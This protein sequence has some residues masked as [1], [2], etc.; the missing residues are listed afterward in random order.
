VFRY[1]PRIAGPYLPA[2]A[3]LIH[4]TS[5]PDEAARA[6][7]GDAIVADVRAFTEAVLPQVKESTR[8][9]PAPRPEPT[10]TQ[11]RH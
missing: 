5:D 7:V 2:G 6:P 9:P 4:V 3:S 11:P 8:N 10:P 1:Y